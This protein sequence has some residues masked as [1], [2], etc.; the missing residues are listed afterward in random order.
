MA[1]IHNIRSK[2][3]DEYIRDK[4]N[5]LENHFYLRLTNEEKRRFNELKTIAD[6]DQYAFDL[7]KQKL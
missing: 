6:V 4:I 7:I 2:E 5:I 1:Q 3:V